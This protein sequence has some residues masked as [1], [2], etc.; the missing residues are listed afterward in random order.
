ME[1]TT[2]TIPVSVYKHL[3]SC[4]VKLD[5]IAQAVENDKSSYGFDSET[6]NVIKLIVGA[7]KKGSVNA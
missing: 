4:E 6:V 7:P 5:V 2:I 1:E 3:S